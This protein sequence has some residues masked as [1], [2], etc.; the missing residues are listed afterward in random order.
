MRDDGRSLVAGAKFLSFALGMAS[1]DVC[2]AVLPSA[3]LYAVDMAN[4][5]VLPYV[6]IDAV[7]MANVTVL[8]RIYV[9]MPWAWPT[10][11]FCPMFQ[12]RDG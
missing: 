2:L 3:F 11:P 12:C 9:P 8:P 6:P 1:S 7:G 10:R 5:T 4:M